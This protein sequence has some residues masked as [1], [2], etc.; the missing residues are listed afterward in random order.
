MYF[1]TDPILLSKIIFLNTREP[2]EEIKNIKKDF[3]KKNK[4]TILRIFA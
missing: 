3:L 4:L 2:R 1:K